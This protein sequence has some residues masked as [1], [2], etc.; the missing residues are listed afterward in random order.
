VLVDP[1]Q[2]TCRLYG[3]DGH[4]TSRLMTVNAPSSRNIKAI[5]YT[6]STPRYTKES[7]QK[8][9]NIEKESFRSAMKLAIVD[10]D[11]DEADEMAVP[12]ED[13]GEESPPPSDHSHQ[14]NVMDT[15]RDEGYRV[16][17]PEGYRDCVNQPV[18]C[19]SSPNSAT[20][21]PA[22]VVEYIPPAKFSE[23][24]RFKINFFDWKSA[25]LTRDCFFTKYD[26]DEVKFADC[27]VERHLSLLINADMDEVG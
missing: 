9:I 21:W 7:F 23:K 20:Y 22:K 4:G 6:E 5:W 16:P 19:K 15:R 1:D 25:K 2:V 13:G 10:T 8:G 24:P 14:S 26:E 18:L 11:I 17:T 27:E 3:D 12:V